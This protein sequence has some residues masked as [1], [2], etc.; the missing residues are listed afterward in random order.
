MIFTRGRH[1]QVET[2]G[3]FYPQASCSYHGWVGFGNIRANGHPNG[4]GRRQFVCLNCRGYFLQTVGTPFQGKQVDPDKL[5]WAIAALAEGLSIRAVARVFEVDPN[6]ILRWL[7]EAA[8]HLEAFSHYHLHDLYVEQ[9]QMDER[10]AL[11]SAVKEGELTEAQAIK[12]LSRSPHWVWVA[13]APVSKHILA[14]DVGDRT[15]AMAQ[16]PVHQVTLAL[17]Y[18][19]TPKLPSLSCRRYSRAVMMMPAGIIRRERYTASGSAKDGYIR[20]ETTIWHRAAST[21]GV[22]RT[23]SL[24]MAAS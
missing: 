22:L 10:F 4:R 17:L 13:M 15:L 12:R 1:R 24:V 5:V 23:P 9:V 20:K 14:V 3:H 6:T 11:L 19:S 7:V 8:E 18:C 2:I 21:E 16:R